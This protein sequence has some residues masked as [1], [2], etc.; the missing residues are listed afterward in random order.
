MD[1]NAG[2][3]RDGGRRRPPLAP[4]AVLERGL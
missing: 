1:G 2:G 3:R 4:R